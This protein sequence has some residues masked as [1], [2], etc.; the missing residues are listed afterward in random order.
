M[1]KKVLSI[2]FLCLVQTVSSQETVLHF[3]NDLKTS[4]SFI[5]DVIPIV[6][7]QTGEIAFLWL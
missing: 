4:S 6:N 2:L 5:K 3:K 1:F 7:K